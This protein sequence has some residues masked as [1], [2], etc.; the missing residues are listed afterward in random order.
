MGEE[1]TTWTCECGRVND[2]NFCMTCGKPRPQAATQD[3]EPATAT[4]SAPQP[5]AETPTE[6]TRPAAFVP[7][8]ANATRP[9]VDPAT[10]AQ[11]SF[12][13]MRTALIAGVAVIALLL[14]YGGYA[15]VSDQPQPA[16]TEQAA[17]PAPEASEAPAKAPE[18]QEKKEEPKLAMPSFTDVPPG[19]AQAALIGYYDD[20]TKR[21]MQSAYGRLSDAMQNQMGVYENFANG[22]Q[23][24]ISSQASDVKVQSSSDTQA[25]LSYT[26][27]SKDRTDSGKTKVQTFRGQATLEKGADGTWKITDMNVKKQ[28]ERME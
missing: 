14:G 16:K 17:V 12:R 5:M 20:I 18:K 27:T 13:A 6:P 4:P 19:S 9:S 10:A 8:A 21:N 23:T 26:L 11:S 3:A 28:G 15:A 25:T 7:P 22:Y 1:K 24:T 2:G